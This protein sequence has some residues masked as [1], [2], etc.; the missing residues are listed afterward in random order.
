MQRRKI[1]PVV[2]NILF[3]S[4]IVVIAGIVIAVFTLKDDNKKK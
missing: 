3:L 1:K 4:I 2:K